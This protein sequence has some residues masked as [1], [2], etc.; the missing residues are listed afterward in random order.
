MKKLFTSE[1]IIYYDLLQ[2]NRFSNLLTGFTIFTANIFS[3][4]IASQLLLMIELDASFNY[5]IKQ[6]S[7]QIFL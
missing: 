2:G 1:S 6:T 5:L 4:K 3:P 7:K